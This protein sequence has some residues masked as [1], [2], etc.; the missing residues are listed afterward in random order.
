MFSLPGPVIE[1]LWTNEFGDIGAEHP[2]E[3]ERIIQ[4]RFEEIAKGA[5]LAHAP[6]RKTTK[7][8]I[9]QMI[10]NE[11]E[12]IKKERQVIEDKKKYWLSQLSEDNKSRRDILDVYDDLY[13]HGRNSIETSL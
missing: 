7:K 4:R 6:T 2:E 1:Q 8:V 9:R 5:A 10:E 13:D 3:L 11:K 12:S